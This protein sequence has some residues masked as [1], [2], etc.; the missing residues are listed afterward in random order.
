MHSVIRFP[1][2]LAT[3][4]DV[5]SRQPSQCSLV[6]LTCSC[7]ILAFLDKVPNIMISGEAVIY[8][9]DGIDVLVTPE[10]PLLNHNWSQHDP[11]G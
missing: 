4:N 11:N 7:R 10:I 8:I 5:V 9:I 1:V 2:Q 6:L 3:A